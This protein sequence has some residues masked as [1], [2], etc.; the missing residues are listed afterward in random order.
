MEK[1]NI[2]VKLVLSG[3]KNGQDKIQKDLLILSDE[4]MA[5]EL[6]PGRNKV[7]WIVG[8]LA[9]VHDS[10]LTILGI[11]DKIN[12]NYYEYFIHDDSRFEAPSISQIRDYWNETSER[13][14]DAMAKLSVAE[15]FGRHT[16]VSAEDF[17]KEPHR[18]KLNVLLTRTYHIHYHYGQFALV[19]NSINA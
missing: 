6:M 8:H 12:E 15:W 19:L 18:N 1:D 14:N 7:S 16:L 2:A 4:K 3:W 10:L 13:L 9:A 5:I 11:G 17:A